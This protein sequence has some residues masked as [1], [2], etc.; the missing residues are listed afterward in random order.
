[1]DGANGHFICCS[2]DGCRLL[3]ESKEILHRFDTGFVTVVTDAHQIFLILNSGRFQCFLV[4]LEPRIAVS[5]ILQR[6]ADHGNLT[7]SVTD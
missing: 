2:K 6:S 7:V 4:T 5:R 3:L 1:M